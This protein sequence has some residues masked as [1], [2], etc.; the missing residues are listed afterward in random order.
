MS[1]LDPTE[2]GSTEVW[3]PAHTRGTRSLAW[4]LLAILV[5]GLVVLGLYLFVL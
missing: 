3:Q 1:N 4:L 2:P 5:V